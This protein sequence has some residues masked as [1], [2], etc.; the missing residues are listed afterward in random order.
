MGKKKKVLVHA[1]C[2]VCSGYSMRKLFEE[3]F[4]PVLFFYNPNIHPK[5]EYKRRLE[6][7]E[8]FCKRNG[9][10]YAI[11]NAGPEAFYSQIKGLE[12]EKERG[13][14]CKKCFALRLEKTAKK[15]AELGFEL[16]T[17]TLSISPHKN[18]SDIKAEAEKIA[19]KHTNV[20]FLDIDFK[21][22][23][24]FLKTNQIAKTQNLY[25]QNYC[26][27]EFSIKN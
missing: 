16:F 11:E 17:T 15:A 24:G 9:Y 10:E 4:S 3:G 23:D 20:S 18:Y 12:L 25:R 14:R 8:G 22:Q 21:K 5:T 26:G 1:C 13:A 6:E 27:C 19:Q 7:F 2:A